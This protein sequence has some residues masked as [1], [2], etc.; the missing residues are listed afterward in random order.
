[1]L[2]QLSFSGFHFHQ[3]QGQI[4]FV[5]LCW[6][7]LFIQFLSQFPSRTAISMKPFAYLAGGPIIM[8]SNVQQQQQQRQQYTTTRAQQRQQQQQRQQTATAT[9]TT[10]A[11]CERQQQ[12]RACFKQPLQQERQQQHRQQQQQQQSSLRAKA[13]SLSPR[14]RLLNG[15]RAA[16]TTGRGCGLSRLCCNLDALRQS[17]R[18]L[19]FVSLAALTLLLLLVTHGDLVQAE[20][21][22][23]KYSKRFTTLPKA[24]GT[25][26][27]WHVV[28]CACY[29]FSCFFFCLLAQNNL[30]A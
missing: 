24:A 14:R 15:K 18:Q 22:V 6:A 5:T 20:G 10:A 27:I 13:S 16:A 7:W 25:T 21:N 19:Q 11:K 30:Q 3:S 17:A 2:P 28:A 9:T 29:C 4:T 23:G 12:H 26:C 1:M 8:A